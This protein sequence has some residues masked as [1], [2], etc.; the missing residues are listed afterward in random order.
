[1]LTVVVSMCTGIYS[2]EKDSKAFIGKGGTKLIISS[3]WPRIMSDAELLHQRWNLGSNNSR[4]NNSKETTEAYP[5]IHPKRTAFE[6]VYRLLK[7]TKEDDIWSS[8]TIELPFQVAEDELDLHRIGDKNSGTFTLYI[9]L[10]AAGGS[11][12][13][14][15]NGSA[16]FM[17]N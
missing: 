14:V 16:M 12:Y 4:K 15:G 7:D 1:M 17:V 6:K 2:R 13:D 9:N 5:K 10:K 11:K 3:K 8:S